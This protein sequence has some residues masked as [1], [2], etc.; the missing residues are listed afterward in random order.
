MIVKKYE[1]NNILIVLKLK[2]GLKWSDGSTITADDLICNLFI[3]M[4]INN[5]AY[6]GESVTKVDDLTVEVKYIKDS[7]LLLDYVLKSALM[8]PV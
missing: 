4:T 6:Y 8:Y 1:K 3:D 2:E 7:S 5:I